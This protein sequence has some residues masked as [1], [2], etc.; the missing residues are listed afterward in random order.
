MYHPREGNRGTESTAASPRSQRA[1]CLQGCHPPHLSLPSFLRLPLKSNFPPAPPPL[2]QPV[3]KST[4]GQG[5]LSKSSTRA[6][7]HSQETVSLQRRS[8]FFYGAP[9]AGACRLPQCTR[10]AQKSGND[11]QCSLRILTCRGKLGCDPDLHRHSQGT[12]PSLHARLVG[13]LLE[14]RVKDVTLQA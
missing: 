13:R 4:H 8:R 9:P 3:N 11:L 12:W 6:S 1:P 7:L 10:E 14:V 5:P 2:R